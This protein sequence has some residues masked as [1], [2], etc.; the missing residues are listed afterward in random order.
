MNNTTIWKIFDFVT[1][2]GVVC[3][4]KGYLFI[5]EEPL[6]VT[7]DELYKKHKT[8][9]ATAKE[10]DKLCTALLKRLDEDFEAKIKARKEKENVRD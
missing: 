8:F 2:S 9:E 7:I 1:V 3:D 5:K 10:I 6:N 4:K